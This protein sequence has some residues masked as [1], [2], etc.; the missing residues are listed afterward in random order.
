MTDSMKHRGPDDRGLY[1][2]NAAGIGLGFR[3]LAIIDLSQAAQ[4]PMSNEDRSVW[5][6]FNG[7]IYNFLT[8]RS[9][10]EKRGHSF[11]SNSDSEVIIH[12]YEEGGEDIFS[13]LNG[14]FGLAI[15]DT[16]KRR[17]IM[18]RDRF[19]KKPLYY[20]HD[21]KRLIFASEL[22]AILADPSVH[23]EINETALSE[24]LALGYISA[25]NTIFKRISKVPPGHRLI[26]EGEKI[27]INRYWD[28]LPA[29]Q[30]KTIRSESEYIDELNSLLKRIVAERLISDVPLGAFL[31]GGVDSSS[32]VAIMAGLSSQPVK[33]FS[34]GF[35]HDAFNELPYARR[36]AEQFK[37]EHHEYIVEPEELRDLVP[38]LVRQFDE[39]FADSSAVPT[40]YVAK[41][42][43][44]EVTVCLSGDG[45]DEAMAGYPRYSKAIREGIVYRLPLDLRRVLF[46]LPAQ[47]LPVGFKGEHMLQRFALSQAERYPFAMRQISKKLLAFLLTSD[48][49]YQFNLYQS[50]SPTVCV[51]QALERAGNLD[52]PSRLQYTDGVTY[53][54]EDI[55]VKVD[56]T[57][58]ANSLE[59]RAPLLDYRFMEF[60]AGLPTNL[61]WRDGK[62]K[63][64][65]KM[66]MRSHL[67]DEILFRKKMGFGIP[68]Q[69][70]FSHE[71]N[72]YASK[73]LLDRQAL[74]RGLWDPEKMKI[75]LKK[76]QNRNAYSLQNAIWVILM[77]EMWWRAYLGNNRTM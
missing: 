13:D 65:F 42:A 63:Y 43:R 14:M 30:T 6:V 66:A 31:S 68:L 70:W 54:P 5:L 45:G 7:E 50:P 23:R 20:Y 52:F 72:G 46:G 77:L 26:Y 57:S 4:Q 36:V 62:G 71:L 55:L 19:G 67:P 34:I 59:V 73:I 1:F 17:L 58:M 60:M 75:L 48:A 64:L 41:M 61:R 51:E 76:A 38:N 56:R 2:D 69:D 53:L 44:Q 21:P 25:P 24:Y 29:F 39:P 74:N 10:L 35:K 3:R 15:W 33:T 27:K 16:H 12:Q 40:Y 9:E 32:V 18:A 22:K 11:R 47:F 28:W 37:T 8:L 49:A